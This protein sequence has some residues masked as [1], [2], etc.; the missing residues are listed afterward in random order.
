MK[1]VSDRPFAD[2]DLPAR[3]LIEIANGVEAV[4]DGRIYIGL[5]NAPFFAAG[6]CGDD[7][8][9]GIAPAIAQGWLWRLESGTFVKFTDSGVALFA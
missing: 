7:F 4:Q 8:R 5:V 9:S 2:P 6:G 3:K 1:F